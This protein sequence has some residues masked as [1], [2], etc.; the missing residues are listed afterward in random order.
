MLFLQQELVCFVHRA[1]V[2]MAGAPH[3]AHAVPKCWL[4]LDC[5]RWW[6]V[7]CTQINAVQPVELEL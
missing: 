3:H 1:A 7:R 2:L 5:S 4:L 6:S